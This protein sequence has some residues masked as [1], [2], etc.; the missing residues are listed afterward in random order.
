MESKIT[1]NNP[2]RVYFSNNTYDGYVDNSCF[3]FVKILCN[4]KHDRIF[5]SVNMMENN[6]F[7]YNYGMQVIKK[8]SNGIIIRVPKIDK[9]D[10]KF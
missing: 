6:S 4:I 3:L 5:H 2:N 7:W 10:I 9:E 8:L 1:M